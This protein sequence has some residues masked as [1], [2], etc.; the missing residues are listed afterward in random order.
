MP[1]RLLRIVLLLLGVLAVLGFGVY[2]TK[3][4]PLVAGAQIDAVTRGRLEAE[5]TDAWLGCLDHPWQRLGI[6][7][8][9]VRLLTQ[10]EVTARAA[11]QGDAMAHVQEAGLVAEVTGYSLFRRPRVRLLMTFDARR[12]AWTRCDVLR[13]EFYAPARGPAEPEGA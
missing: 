1:S 12:L 5:V 10:E 3:T 8:R 13:D 9:H 2:L 11:H 7:R 4:A 6:I